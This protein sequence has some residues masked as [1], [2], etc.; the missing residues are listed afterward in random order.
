MCINQRIR[1]KNHI[2]YIYCVKKKEQITYSICNDCK[3]KDYKKVKPIKKSKVEIRK[4]SNKLAKL[5][6]NRFSI[7]TNDLLHCYICKIAYKDDFNEVFGGSNRQ[8]SMKY[9]LVIPVCRKCHS[10][11][12]VNMKLR[13]EIQQK[14]KVEFFK[15]HTEE[16]FLKEFGKNYIKRF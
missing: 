16:E 15:T 14:A 13:E 4:K 2:K 1:S 5:E 7:L 8:K 3:Y 10:Q 9:G 12:D 6:R 11:Y